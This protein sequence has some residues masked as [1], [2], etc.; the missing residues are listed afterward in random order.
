MKQNKVH[1][2]KSLSLVRSNS[3]NTSELL[4]IEA[5]GISYG[6]KLGVPKLVP[7]SS[8]GNDSVFELNFVLLGEVSAISKDAEYSIKVVYKLDELPSNIAAVKVNAV[9]NADII[10]IND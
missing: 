1:L 10:I 3:N 2:L 7:V 4:L 9:Q 6:V 5:T 8:N